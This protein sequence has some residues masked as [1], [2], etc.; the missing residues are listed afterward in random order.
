MCKSIARAMSNSCQRIHV[1]I[2]ILGVVTLSTA[3]PAKAQDGTHKI[4]LELAAASR[5]QPSKSELAFQDSLAETTV[6]TSTWRVR[7]ISPS[8]S[9]RRRFFCM[10]AAVYGFAFLDMHETASLKPDLIEHDPLAQPFTRLPTPAYYASGVAMVTGVNWAAWK[11][12]HSRRWRKVWWLPQTATAAG[13]LW[14]YGS[15][16]ARE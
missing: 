4:K 9:N 5:T 15:T 6:P 13:N 7:P 10:S 12:L 11:M 1:I 14:G 16:R 8:R 3:L 2:C